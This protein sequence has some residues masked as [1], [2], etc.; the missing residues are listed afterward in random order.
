MK[1]VVF[2]KTNFHILLCERVP[3]F[4]LRIV[5]ISNE[6]SL[7]GIQLWEWA[8]QWASRMCCFNRRVHTWY[9]YMCC[10]LWQRGWTTWTAGAVD[11]RVIA[12]A[13][14]VL[15]S[16]NFVKVNKSWS[17]LNLLIIQVHSC[18]LSNAENAPANIC[19]L[20]GQDSG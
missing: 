1:T 7:P 17:L 20:V 6:C 11:K 13:P 14:I 5:R 19:R 8:S 15:T 12:M 9:T 4:R 16:L 10:V 3:C 18:V 2:T